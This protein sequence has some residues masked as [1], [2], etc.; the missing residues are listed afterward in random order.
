MKKVWFKAKQYGWGWY[1]S[2]WQAWLI[3][4]VYFVLVIL[5]FF[6]LDAMSHSASDT[7]RPWIID[8]FILGIMLVLIAWITGEEPRWRWGEKRR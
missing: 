8:I 6:R 3:L 5:D 4:F 1:P 7:I 2:T